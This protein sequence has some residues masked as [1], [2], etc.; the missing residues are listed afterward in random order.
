MD[1]RMMNMPPKKGS[2]VK[3]ILI[4]LGIVLALVVVGIVAFALGKGSDKKSNKKGD[5]V[6]E[7]EEFEDEDFDDGEDEDSD[8]EEASLGKRDIPVL[9]TQLQDYM[10]WGWYMPTFNG[11]V[12]D[13][14]DDDCKQFCDAAGMVTT[15]VTYSDD[16]VE[17]YYCAGLPT[18]IRIGRPHDVDIL[19]PAMHEQDEKK[20]L[21][22][23]GYPKQEELDALRQ[24]YVETF[25][26]DGIQ[27]Y[28][29]FL[30]FM[31]TT[32]AEF[33]ICDESGY[34]NRIIH[35]IVKVDGNTVSFVNYKKNNQTA[36]IIEG[37]TILSFEAYFDG[38]AMVLRNGNDEVRYLPYD[39]TEESDYTH[40]LGYVKNGDEAY[41]NIV[42]IYCRT[43]K[44]DKTEKCYIEC[45]NG[46][47]PIDPVMEANDDGTFKIS[48]EE[49]WRSTGPYSSDRVSDPFSFSGEYLWGMD[50][51]FVLNI[52]G[53][54][55]RYQYTSREYEASVIDI[56]GEVYEDD[57]AQLVQTQNYINNQ[58]ITELEAEGI[59]ARTDEKGRIV[60][61][62]NVLFA[63]DSDEISETGQAELERF[64]AVY[65]KIVV[66]YIQEGSVL[67]VEVEGHTDTD[68]SYD[69]NLDLS[70]RRA[71]AVA[72][73]GLN[74]QPELG[75]N[76]KAQGYSFSDPVLDESGNVDKAASRRVVFKIVLNK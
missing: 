53:E 11:E 34:I 8:D 30:K 44:E 75:Q 16:N 43:D 14:R 35:A 42:K 21:G 62:T 61:D 45:N 31:D 46:D 32:F 58:L 56:E 10:L 4:I 72:N 36:E 39:H 1:E 5:A 52:D 60:L 15:T 22:I 73:Y 2:P 17:E 55:Y 26:E 24:D 20:G 59:S 66:P 9:G 64:L 38:I 65:A 40:C 54:I 29:N 27:Y 12:F 63:V 3:I 50:S 6:T 51:G 67:Y 7:D 18:R 76:M 13:Y 47:M 68:G 71:E 28:Q 19:L 49:V 70:Q 23:V 33:T 41:H 69:Y 37:D 25:G 48:W 57:I 74:V